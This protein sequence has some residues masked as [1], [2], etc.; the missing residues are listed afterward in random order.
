MITLKVNPDLIRNLIEDQKENLANL[1]KENLQ[2][3]LFAADL[4]NE[5]IF[6]FA[7]NSEIPLD[8]TDQHFL[9]LGYDSSGA[10]YFEIKKSDQTNKE[11]NLEKFVQALDLNELQRKEI[12]SIIASYSDELLT[13][14][15]VSDKNTVAINPEL[16]NY[17]KAIASEILAFARNN[18]ASVYNSIL[19]VDV[20][21]LDDPQIAR[22]VRYNKQSDN[23]KYIF[24]TPDSIFADTFVFDDTDFRKDMQEVEKD[25]AEMSKDLVKINYQI[26]IDTTFK[27]LKEDAS[28]TEEF[29]VQFD[30]DNFKVRI[31]EII[32]SKLDV[33]LPNMDSINVF[34]NEVIKKAQAFSEKKS[35]KHPRAKSFN[36]EYHTIDSL[37]NKQFNFDDSRIDS[38]IKK[39]FQNPDSLMKFNFEE[40]DIFSDSGSKG[41][42]FFFNDSS[43]FNMNE[44]LRQQMNDLKEEM[45]RFRQEMRNFQFD[46]PDLPDT[47]K[48]ELKGIEI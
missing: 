11:N 48:P 13:Q 3:L 44:E 40:F 24:L 33:E 34:I 31:P 5:D 39:R 37:N 18:N 30:A 46:R 9:K 21:V 47:S 2:P 22:L 38:L 19:P 4:T 28:W 26:K 32:I 45:K 35:G 17:R 16:W 20:R 7:F 29:S 41:F 8:K 27:R 14:V 42:N 1:Y 6:N 23:Q 15:L 25:L 43:M 12:D 36:F 10:E